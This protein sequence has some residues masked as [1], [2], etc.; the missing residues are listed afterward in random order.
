MRLK[1]RP[2]VSPLLR[3]KSRCFTSL[4]CESSVGGGGGSDWLGEKPVNR[5][6]EMVF[7]D[8]VGE[9]ELMLYKIP[10]VR[11]LSIN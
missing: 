8:K 10:S 1:S 2:I 5:L 6:G 3:K 11:R 9:G 7:G 4:S